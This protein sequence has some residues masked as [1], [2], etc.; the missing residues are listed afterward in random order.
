M[1]VYSFKMLVLFEMPDY[2]SGRT[3]SESHNSLFYPSVFNKT[4]IFL[5][6]CSVKD[7]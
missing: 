1:G 2:Y 6:Y 7:L 3:F 5:S 4:V